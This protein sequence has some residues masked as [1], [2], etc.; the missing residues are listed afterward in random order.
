MIP[1]SAPRID[2]LI[3]DEVT[4]TLRSG[5]V[6]TGPKTKLFEKKLSEYYGAKA[7]LCLNSATAGL[8][9]MLRWYGVGAGDEVILSAYTFAATA[10]VI[11]HCGATPV[12]VDVEEDFNISPQKI[13]AAITTKTKVIIPVDFAGFPA[14]YTPIFTVVSDARNAFTP[15]NLI[16]EELGRIL[17]VSDS[18][19]ALGATYNYSK[20]GTQADAMV[21]SFHASKNLTTAE[22]GA[23]AL[24]L[25][26]PFDNEAIYKTLCIQTLHGQTKDAYAKAQQHSWKYDVIEAG[27]KYNMPDLAASIG[28]VELQRY[29]AETLPKR[30][31]I[32]DF[33]TEYFEGFD[34][35]QLP[36]AKTTQSE[37]SYHIYALRIKGI[38]E[39]Q[40][41]EITRRIIAAG[42]LVNVH[43]MPVPALTYY[44]NLGYNVADYPVA[45]DNYS[46]EISLPVFYD[47]TDE[48][49]QTVA[50]VVVNCVEQIVEP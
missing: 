28:L 32:F 4:N 48:Q 2:Q 25:P 46:R 13:A 34:W 35:A 23:I 18:A 10:N 9:T 47:L 27:Y 16:Q 30:K 17:V 31:Q 1:F 29:D 36:V 33:Y 39:E 11:I 37:T 50:R 22:G 26:E 49:M 24:N 42:V 41:D 45:Y 14:N 21:F 7:T 3:V 38:T 19:H 43:F 6:G 5:W 12:F 40:R 8:E 44:K 15:T 20:I